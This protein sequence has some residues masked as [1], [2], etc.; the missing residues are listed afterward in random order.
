MEL[1]TESHL[2]GCCAFASTLWSKVF[3]W[4]CWIG[5]VPRDPLHIFGKFNVGRG[6][7]KRL[8]GLLAVWHAVVWAIWKVRNDLIFNAK[9]PVMEDVFQGIIWILGS[10]YVKKRRGLVAHFMNGKHFLWIVSR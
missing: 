9:V 3:N 4:F 8:K 7:G 6:N 1:E 10:G 5:V 2:F